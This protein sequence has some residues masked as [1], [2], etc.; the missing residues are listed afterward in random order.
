MQRLDRILSEAGVASRKELRAMIRA[1]RV[2][3]DGAAVTDE[4][5][6]FDE[7]AVR[8]T[9]D[10]SPVRLRGPVLILL[11][12]PAGYLTA[13]DDPKA[14]SIMDLVPEAYRKLGV[15]PVGRLDKDTEGLLLLTNDGD[16]AHRILSPRHGVWK[17]YY[18]EHEG[19]AGPADVRAFE[20]GLVLADG[21]HCLPAKLTP[22]GPGRSVVEVQEGKYHGAADA[23]QPRHA[24]HVPAPRGRGPADPRRSAARADKRTEYCGSGA[25]SFEYLVIL[26]E[27][28]TCII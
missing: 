14:K 6:K 25:A 1:G 7:T 4:S 23:R 10:G 16:L 12:K 17:R 2:T 28:K 11:H 19:T 22:L 20:A 5:R 27:E 8:V 3:V 24:G 15:M 13:A 18:A 26:T 21:L 9:V